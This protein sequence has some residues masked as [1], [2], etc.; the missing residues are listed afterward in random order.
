MRPGCSETEPDAPPVARVVKEI[1]VT[2]LVPC[3]HVSNLGS[4]DSERRWM[5]RPESEN[6]PWP[7]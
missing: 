1:L 4:S 6:S 5:E 2:A 3:I 7:S